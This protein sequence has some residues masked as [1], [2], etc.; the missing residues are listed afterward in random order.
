MNLPNLTSTILVY[1]KQLIAGLAFPALRASLCF[2]L[3]G[4]RVRSV[5]F[6]GIRA[7]FSGIRTFSASVAVWHS[8]QLSLSAYSRVS[9]SYS[10][11]R[12]VAVGT[13]LS[14]NKSFLFLSILLE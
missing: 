9:Y 3:L 8:S 5:P 13:R 14:V 11:N 7:P 6:P 4:T 1:T 10:K 2:S 12:S